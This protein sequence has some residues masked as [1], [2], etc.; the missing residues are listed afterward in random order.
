MKVR[1]I[2]TQTPV[3]CGRETNLGAAVELLWIH[4]CG[5]LPVVDGNKKLI[6]IVTDRDF[7]IALGTRNR[8]PGDLTVGDVATAR[9]ISC[10]ADDEIHVALGT[11]ADHQV[12]RLPVVDGDGVPR[13]ILSMDDVLVHADQNKWEGSCELSSEE[14]IRSIKKMR[15]QQFPIIHH[16]KPAARATVLPREASVGPRP[17]NLRPR[18]NPV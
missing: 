5:M 16:P 8:L 4:N 9:V 6:G 18:Q 1:D 13:G 11:M 7:C 2:M 10:K 3:C 15:G 17:I 14:V 12:R